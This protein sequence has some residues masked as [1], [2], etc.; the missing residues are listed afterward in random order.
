M[1][2][3]PGGQGLAGLGSKSAIDV[4]AAWRFKCRVASATPCA[5]KGAAA[6]A[7]RNSEK[8]SNKYLQYYSAMAR[9][10]TRIAYSARSR[11]LQTVQN[12]NLLIFW[13]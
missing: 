5:Y 2:A 3:D 1:L 9:R 11:Q 13:Y 12:Q 7:A 10:L 4:K 8:G 6:E